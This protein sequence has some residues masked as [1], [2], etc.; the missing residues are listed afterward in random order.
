MVTK[1]PR[2]LKPVSRRAISKARSPPVPARAR[3]PSAAGRHLALPA[4][5]P[6]TS[7]RSAP[8]RPARRATRCLIGI[9]V[10]RTGTYAVQGEDELKGWQL[11]VEHINA[12]HQL[13][14]KISPKTT[15]GVLGKE[16]KFGVADSA[17]KPNDAVQA[18][19]RFITENKAILMTG[20]TSSAV[21]VALN[22]LAQREK[23]LYV[24]RHLRL[25][26]HHRQGLRALRLP[27]ELLRRDRGQRD[28]PGAGQGLR[29]EQEGGVHDAGL[30][31]RP[32]RHQVGERLPDQE[33]RLDAW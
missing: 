6:R 24:C 7:R 33:R 10:P 3:C 16:V 28:R 18:Q 21:A 8:G 32:H 22:K 31:L 29:Q 25:E 14:K 20:S 19:Q 12:G 17:A 23:V 1:V 26:R 13:I 9:A 27:P 15:K 5:G 2:L 4:P 30:H 11:A